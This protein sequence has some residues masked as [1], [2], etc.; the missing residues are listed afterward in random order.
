M[1]V[2]E[3][4]A[5]LQVIENNHCDIKNKK[6]NVKKWKGR[7]EEEDPEKDGEKKQKEILCWE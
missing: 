6:G 5:I 2:K 7:D 1:E 3:Q 4:H